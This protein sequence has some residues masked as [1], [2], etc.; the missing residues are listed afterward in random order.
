MPEVTDQF[1]FLCWLGEKANIAIGPNK[2]EGRDTNAIVRMP[3][4][5]ISLKEN[6]G[7][8]MCLLKHFAG[9]RTPL[10]LVGIQKCVAG[11]AMNDQSQFPGQVKGILN[12]RICSLAAKGTMHMG[13]H[14]WY[15]ITRTTIKRRIAIWTK[16]VLRLHSMQQGCHV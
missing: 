15:V 3:H 7:Q 8:M 2:D 9:D 16:L 1:P 13:L 14:P 4:E 5:R 6:A 11:F 12:A 10:L